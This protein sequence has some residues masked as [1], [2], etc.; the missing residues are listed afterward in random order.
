[1][2]FGT[3]DDANLVRAGQGNA[4]V[5]AVG[6][7][8]DSPGVGGAEVDIV[9]QDGIDELFGGHVDDGQGIGVHPAAFELRG[10]QLVAGENVCDV[11]VFAVRTYGDIVQC[12]TAV[13][14]LDRASTSIPLN[15]AEGNGKRSTRDRCRYFDTSRG[16]ALEP[17]AALDVLVARR[18]LSP[19]EVQAGKALLLRIVEML[20]KLTHTLLAAA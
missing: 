13:G 2:H 5:L 8:F 11:S 15:I 12:R 14:Q 6:G 4:D 16:S 1:M 10:G 9:Q 18:V 20:S 17:A 7:A 19:A 3:I